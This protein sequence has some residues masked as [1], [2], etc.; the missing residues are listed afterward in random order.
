M[1][2]SW[3]KVGWIWLVLF[4]VWVGLAVFDFQTTPDKGGYSPSNPRFLAGLIAAAS[5]VAS[6]VGFWNARR[7]RA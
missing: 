3:T 4:F 7:P 6:L 1:N 5:A 2:E